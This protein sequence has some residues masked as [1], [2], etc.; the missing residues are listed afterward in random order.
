MGTIESFLGNAESAIAG[1]RDHLPLLDERR[2]ARLVERLRDDLGVDPS[3]ELWMASA[4]GRSELG[5]NHTDHQRGRVLAASINLDALAAVSPREDEIVRI[6]SEGFDELEVNLGDLEPRASEHNTTEALVRGVAAGFRRNGYGVAGFDATVTSTVLAGS[7]LSSSA[8]IEVLIG[9][10]FDRLSND[11]AAG[12]TRIAQI[13]QYAENEF[14]GKPAGLMDQVACA[15]GGA[16]KI[17]F[18]DESNPVI[19]QIQVTF[20]SAGLA[21]LVVD[22]GGSHAGLTHEYAAIPNEMRAIARALGGREL[23]DVEPQ[24]FYAALSHLREEVGDRAVARALHFF[25]ENPRVDGMAAA[26]A[27]GRMDDYL[28]LMADS[29]RSSAVFLQNCVPQG[30]AGEQAVVIALALSEHFFAAAGLRN[31]RDAACRVHGGGFAGTI[32]VL[33]PTDRV[34]EYDAFVSQHLGRGA[35]TR[36]AIRTVGAVAHPV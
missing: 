35:V 21:L 3:R 17:D 1:L 8:S 31:G 16:V 7:G 19:E 5:G 30:D 6:A 28:A 32:Q 26:L 10:I 25:D 29:G 22:T 4:P 36:L 18:Q 15:T 14:F 11:G 34:A 12:P 9:T 27:A 2:F 33:L 24:A 20:E 23:R 13:G